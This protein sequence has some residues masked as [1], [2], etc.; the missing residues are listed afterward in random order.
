[1]LSFLS[2]APTE[3]VSVSLPFFG[4]AR[5]WLVVSSTDSLL[6]LSLL[7]TLSSFAFA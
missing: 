6:L 3:F 5:T 2:L 4:S 1:M 7:A